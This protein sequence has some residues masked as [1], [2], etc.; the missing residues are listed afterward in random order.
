MAATAPTARVYTGH[1]LKGAKTGRWVGHAVNQVRARHQSADRPN[2][3][4]QARRASETSLIRTRT[5]LT[6]IPV[7]SL[8]VLGRK[9]D[10]PSFKQSAH[11]L[12]RWRRV[13][14]SISCEVA[15]HDRADEWPSEKR[16][17]QQSQHHVGPGLAHPCE[18]V[19]KRSPH[20]FEPIRKTNADRRAPDASGHQG[21][22]SPS[23]CNNR[24]GPRG[25]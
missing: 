18:A 5:V 23:S 1:S 19:S 22:V 14:P 7:F 2:R 17:Q 11:L 6:S 12:A 16:F 13:N 8:V 21:P 20:R 24:P 3:G 9:S 25:A 4:V 10:R 15:V